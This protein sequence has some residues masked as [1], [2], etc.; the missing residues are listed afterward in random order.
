MATLTKRQQKI[1][2]QSDRSKAIGKNAKKA[3]GF[4]AGTVGGKGIKQIVGGMK[5]LL[6]K[7][8]GRKLRKKLIS[9]NKAAVS[10]KV[11]KK[12]VMTNEQKKL[13]VFQAREANKRIADQAKSEAKTVVKERQGI[14]KLL[15]K[16][17]ARKSDLKKV[18]KEFS[19][20]RDEVHPAFT[21]LK[22]KKHNVTPT[23]RHSLPS[24][25]K[26]TRDKLKK[27]K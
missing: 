10:P 24:L 9:E 7:A 11:L 26:S 2:E 8:Q 25:N 23:G 19:N 17:K 3:L 6:A 20:E 27:K 14:S 4:I 5:N 1:K 18:K 16:S 13:A 22:P 12:K 21:G 15:E